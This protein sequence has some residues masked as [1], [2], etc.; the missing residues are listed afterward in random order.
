MRKIAIIFIIA[1]VLGVFV[2]VASANS[3]G[4]CKSINYNGGEKFLC[5]LTKT[6]LGW[7]NNGYG[8][9]YGDNVYTE[10]T[11]FHSGGKRWNIS[12]INAKAEIRIWSSSKKKWVVEYKDVENNRKLWNADAETRC[13]GFLLNHKGYGKQYFAQG[14]FSRYYVQKIDGGI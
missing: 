9:K 5:Y 13:G 8:N 4:V 14:S 11:A 1:V 2:P 10:A 6:W 3:Q 7:N 12:Y